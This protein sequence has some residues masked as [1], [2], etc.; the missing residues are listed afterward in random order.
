MEKLLRYRLTD[1]KT[2]ADLKSNAEG[3]MRVGIQPSIDTLI[4]I[5]L[6]E[7]ENQQENQKILWKED[8]NA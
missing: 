7:Y 1:P 3:L 2:A 8:K 5:K 6:A 4:Y